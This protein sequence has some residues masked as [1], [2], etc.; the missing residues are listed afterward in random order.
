MKLAFRSIVTI[1][2]LSICICLLST[3]CTSIDYDIEASIKPPVYDSTVVQGTWSINKFISAAPENKSPQINLENVKI[4]YLDKWAVFDSELGAIGIDTCLNPEYRIV[5]TK[6]DSFIQT[7]YRTDASKLGLG[8]EEVAVVNIT[9]E[10]QLFYDVIVTDDLKAYVYI[11]NG[12]LELSRTSAE[13]ASD[14][15]EKSLKNVGLNIHKGHYEEDPLLRSGVLLGIR[16]SDNSYRTLWLYSKNRELITA[17][18]GEN[19]LVPRAKGFWC[20]GAFNE[21]NIN[22]IY[23][24]PIEDSSVTNL[25]GMELLITSNILK[26]DSTTKINFVGNDYIGTDTDGKLRVYPVESLNAESEVAFSQI[27][28]VQY[29]K[30]LEQATMDYIATLKPEN[31]NKLDNRVDNKNYTLVRRNG[32]WVLRSR[33]FYMEP[34]TERFVDFDLNQMVPAGLI[35]YDEMAI[36]WNTIKAKLPWTTDAFMSPNKEII[37]LIDKSSLSVY[38][39]QNKSIINKQLFKIKLEKGES[40][41][42][43]EWS[44]GR[45]AEIWNDYFNK[46]YMEE[47]IGP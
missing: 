6:A 27:P 44:V 9:S 2:S 8:K 30:S 14:L 47:R 33:L 18:Q 26:I 43:A 17:G 15:K 38:T 25:K 37:V 41:V 13:V 20:V 40:I 46:V 16:T 5:K 12:F 42:M 22:A 36:P 29:E 19:L 10:N 31:K 11:D 35:H 21:N 24:E 3:G 32:H 28:R 34:E 1:I 4:N 39:I 7:K 23:A 45:Y